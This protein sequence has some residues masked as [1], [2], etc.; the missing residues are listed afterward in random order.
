MVRRDSFVSTVGFVA[1]PSLASC[2]LYCSLS[3][4]Y[5]VVCVLPYRAV[6]TLYPYC[7]PFGVSMPDALLCFL[8]TVFPLVL[9]WFVRL[10]Y[11][12]QTARISTRSAVWQSI[13]AVACV[14]VMVLCVS[15]VSG[16]FDRKMMVVGSESMSGSLEKGDVVIYDKYDGE[17]VEVG[18]IVLF[19]RDGTTI[20]HRVTD[21]K[22]IDG[23]CRYYTK[24][25]ANEGADSGYVTSA[26]L[27]GVVKAKIPYLGYP[28][29]WLHD[30][31]K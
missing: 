8:K 5:G 16:V 19:D 22:N 18:R 6:V 9:L 1:L 20:I 14:C 30:L 17:T 23:V 24:G 13:A 15:F 31:F 26:D 11:K 7:I 10:L 2:L 27:V 29:V 4:T 21:V 12:K 25:D 28:T 3:K